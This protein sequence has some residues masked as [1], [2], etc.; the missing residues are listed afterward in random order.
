MQHS[1]MLI[2]AILIILISVPVSAADVPDNKAVQGNVA[3]DSPDTGNPLKVGM[4][5]VNFGSN[6][7]SVSNAD[8]TDWYANRVLESN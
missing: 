4:K 6:P 2:K 3:S 8:R 7:T 1:S 5:A